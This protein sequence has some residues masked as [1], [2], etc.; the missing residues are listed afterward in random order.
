M[1]SA[2]PSWL[3]FL[4]CTTRL[5]AVISFSYF[6]K[7]LTMRNFISYPREI[8]S[9]RVIQVTVST[10][11]RYQLIANKREPIGVCYCSYLIHMSEISG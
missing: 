1:G 5:S 6:D 2:A 9:S 11:E 7:S 10:V 4:S 8:L 3:S